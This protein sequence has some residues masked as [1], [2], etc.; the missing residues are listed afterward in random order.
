M[1]TVFLH[2][3]HYHHH[4]SL[5][6]MELGHLLTRSGRTYPEVSSKVYHGTVFLY[7]YNQPDHY[8]KMI[9]KT[10]T[11]NRVSCLMLLT[12]YILLWFPFLLRVSVWKPIPVAARLL[13][14]RVRIPL[15]AWISVALVSVVC[16]QVEVCATSRSL[17]QRSL[18]ECDVSECDREAWIMRRPWPT[19][20]CCVI[21]GGDI[22]RGIIKWRLQSCCLNILRNYMSVVG[23]KV[24]KRT[25]KIHCRAD[26]FLNSSK[27]L[28]FV[29]N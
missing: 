26:D 4:H 27:E 21:G 6:F 28:S 20:S 18:T 19:R 12:K 17:V 25:C 5:S 22:P 9:V 8:F 29:K 1:C 10:V 16:C 14:L 11:T 15:G 23:N 2:H 7:S 13:G 3:L 24:L